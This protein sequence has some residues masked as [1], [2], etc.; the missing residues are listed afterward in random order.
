[1]SESSFPFDPPVALAPMEGLTSAPIRD[2][3]AY[4]GG[5]GLV[6]TEFV[7]IYQRPTAA[8]LARALRR[9]PAVALSVQLMGNDAEHMAAA[10]RWLADAGVDVVDVNLGCPT[11][12][13]VRGGVGAALLRDHSALRRVLEA[14]RKA[15]TGLLS[16]K[17]RAGFDRLDE[18]CTLGSM[19]ADCGADYLVVHPRRGVD[20]YQGVADWRIVKE[21]TRTLRIPIVGN[22]D[23][24]YA[25]DALRLR[26]E[27]GCDAVMIGRPALRNPWIFRQLA[28][29]AA[30]QTPFSPTG[31]DLLGH[32][33]ELVAV[34]SATLP[35]HR[36]LGALKEHVRY[37]SRAVPDG[38]AFT[39]AAVRLDSTAAVLELAERCLGHRSPSELDLEAAAGH[40]LERVPAA[41]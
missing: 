22:G 6:C 20:M 21:L 18:A 9:S 5:L 16:A 41:I 31:E 28:E 27:T 13:A 2:L 23:I 1:M 3:F 4:R 26:A 10:T 25:Q 24:W 19:V 15:T 33:D 36:R 40:G 32:L 35:E 7:R 34:F 37:L 11:R 12:R 38:G 29:L 14:M 30:N 8:Q 17:L 39:R